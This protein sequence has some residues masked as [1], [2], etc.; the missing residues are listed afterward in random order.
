MTLRPALAAASMIVWTPRVVN[1]SGRLSGTEQ[2]VAL[3]RV[4]LEDEGVRFSAAGGVS[5][6]RY[7]WEP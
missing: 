2:G 7:L 5:L 1:A 4:L 6:R 3:R